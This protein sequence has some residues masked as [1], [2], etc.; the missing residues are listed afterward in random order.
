MFSEM[1]EITM[2]ETS[3]FLGIVSGERSRGH[4]EV[5]D[6]AARFAGGLA[7]NRR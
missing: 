7:R 4:A 3:P 1:N 5:A 6:R 2:T